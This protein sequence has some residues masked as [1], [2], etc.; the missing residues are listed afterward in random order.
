MLASDEFK[1][2]LSKVEAEIQRKYFRVISLDLNEQRMVYYAMIDKSELT[3]RYFPTVE[4]KVE[5][6]VRAVIKE[7]RA[8]RYGENG[9]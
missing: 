9:V 2:F 1:T 7:R 6:A 8:I 4:D 5:I 3:S